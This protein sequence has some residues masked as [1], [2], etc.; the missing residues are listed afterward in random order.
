METE[1]RAVPA[2]PDVGVTTIPDIG[3]NFLS[4]LLVM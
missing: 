3:I 1:A 2:K 4:M